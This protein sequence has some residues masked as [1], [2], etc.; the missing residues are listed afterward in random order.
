ML[1]QKAKLLNGLIPTLH[2]FLWNRFALRPFFGAECE[3]YI[4]PALTDAALDALARTLKSNISLFDRLER[5]QGDGQ[6]E[7]CLQYTDDTQVLIVQFEQ[8]KKLIADAHPCDFSPKPFKDQPA[9][10]LH[11]H[12][13]LENAEGARVYY[14]DDAQMSVALQ[15]SIAGLLEKMPEAVARLWTTEADRARIT[16]N[17]PD[18]PKTISWGA[19]NRSCAIRLPDKPHDKKHIEYRLASANA[20]LQQVLECVLDGIGH[21]LQTKPVLPPQTYGNAHDAQYQLIKLL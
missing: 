2:N 4:Q 19:N 8:C 16:S 14:K 10:G 18:V 9:S 21:G 20:D 12:V 13:H 11:V 1:F 5:E 17:Q 3:F 7:F 6:L 15:Y